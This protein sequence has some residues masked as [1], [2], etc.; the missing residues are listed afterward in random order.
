MVVPTGLTKD[1]WLKK[2]K[3]NGGIGK[4]IKEGGGEDG[5]GEMSNLRYGFWEKDIPLPPKI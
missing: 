3:K 1:L 2:K 4:K 5:G